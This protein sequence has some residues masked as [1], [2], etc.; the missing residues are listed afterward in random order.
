M[1]DKPDLETR[2]K[3]YSLI[4]QNPGINLSRVAELLHLSVQLVDY[5]LYSMVN[6][7]LITIVKDKG[8]KRCYIKGEIGTED[9]RILAILRQDVPLKIVTYLVNNPYS[10][11]R[12][13][14]KH[15]GMKSPRFSYYLKK[16]VK[17]NIVMVAVIDDRRGYVVVNEKKIIEIIIRHKPYRISKMVEDTWEDFTRD[18]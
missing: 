7:E 15:L 2:R 5:H 6:H 16:L 13:I 1:S 14:L 9:R 3:I 8:Y 10:R 17:N 18:L 11:Y 4:E 12:D